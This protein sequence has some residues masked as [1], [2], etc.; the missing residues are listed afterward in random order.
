[1]RFAI[2]HGRILY[3][4]PTSRISFSESFGHQSEIH[5]LCR[6]T[7]FECVFQPLTTCKLN[8]KELSEA[9]LLADD[10]QLN[11]YPLREVRVVRLRRFPRKSHCSSCLSPWTGNMELFDQLHIGLLG[12]VVQ[13]DDEYNLVDT[14]LMD[15]LDPESKH[16]GSM[17]VFMETNPS[18]LDGIDDSIF[19]S[20]KTM[21]STVYY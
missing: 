12:F 10:R 19:S 17:S 3:L 21:V 15:I 9:V 4:L 16:L 18:V 20:L 5:S 2:C 8:E 13:V 11:A 7:L 1:M 6:D 14:T